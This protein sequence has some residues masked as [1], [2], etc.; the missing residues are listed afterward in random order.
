MDIFRCK[1]GDQKKFHT[2]RVEI[3]RCKKG[4]QKKFH[5]IR[6][7]IFRCNW[8]RGVALV[9][10]ISILLFLTIGIISRLRGIKLYKSLTKPLSLVAMTFNLNFNIL[11]LDY[12]S[13]MMVHNL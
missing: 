1:K 6:V 3:F 12:C 10:P 5:T 9:P 4:D 7:E 8:K 2:I 13:V 11:K